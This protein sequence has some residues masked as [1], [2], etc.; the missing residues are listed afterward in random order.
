MYGGCC[1]FCI[2]REIEN[3]YDD[4]NC[5]YYNNDDTIGYKHIGDGEV[6]IFVEDCC[7]NSTLIIKYCPMC[8]R[9]L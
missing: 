5:Y 2:I 1:R 4:N 9:K 6:K 7:Y 3:I 8:G